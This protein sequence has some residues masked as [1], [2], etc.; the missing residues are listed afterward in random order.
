MKSSKLSKIYTTLIYICLYLPIAVMILFSFNESKSMTNFT[1]FSLKW[2]KELF[3]S[4]KAFEALKYSLIIA[5]LSAL[6]STVIGTLAAYGIFHMRRKAVKRA[7]MSVTNIPMMNPDIVTGISMLLLFAFVQLILGLQTSLLGFGTLLIAHI[8]F[9]IPYVILSVLPKLRQMDPNLSEAAMDLGCTPVQTFFRVELPSVMPGIV[10]GLIMAFTLSL[11]D[12]VISNFTIGNSFQTLPILIYSMTKR[13]VTPDMN[14]LCSIMFVVIFALLLI[15]NLIDVGDGAEK[16]KVR[17]S[18][19]KVKILAAVLAVVIVG[20]TAAVV[21]VS[22]PT[23]EKTI[24]VYNW[25]EY[26]SDG[27]EDSLDVIA[28]FEDWYLETYGEKVKVNYT[29][30]AS[31]EDMYNKIKSGASDYD[32][33]IPSDYMIVKM[34]NEGMLEE[35]DYS[36]IPNYD[37]NIL[38]DFKGL[39]YDPDQKY[40]V[41]YTYG[42]IGIIYNSELVDEEDATGWDLMWNPKYSGEILQ[43]NN[44]RDAFGSAMYKL[45]IDVNTKDKAEWQRAFDELASQKPIIQSYVMDEI[46][47]KMESGEAAV[48][49]YY[50][51]DYLFMYENN[52]SL[53]FVQP[54]RTN[55]YIDAMC[56]PKNPARS[57]ETKAIACRFINFMIDEEAAVAN[58]EMVCYASP[59]RVVIENEEYIEYMNEIRED[60]MDILYPEDLDFKEQYSLY[61]YQGLSDEYNKNMNELWSKLKISSGEEV[62]ITNYVALGLFVII[63]GYVVFILVR[64]KKRAGYY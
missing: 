48:S 6:I 29:T 24:S 36:L 33:I 28:A 59:N 35:L 1:G 50:A 37:S 32:V 22:D 13:E 56:M 10:S 16:K 12:F 15:S 60:A 64:R 19:K 3:S 46:Y 63:A 41:P 43:F 31:C 7:V 26:I 11:D 25:G 55:F 53:E 62:D 57:A 38:D 34:R 20:G 8:T 30:F 52:D 27:S 49:A 9:N 39:Y 58:A 42:A 61:C 4:G 21:L 40:T 44:P 5:V 2:Y 17:M 23:V 45:G 47:N 14:A 51:G 54:E 18:K